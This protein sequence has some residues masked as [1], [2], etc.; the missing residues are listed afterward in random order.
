MVAV[1]TVTPHSVR[2]WVRLERS[3]RMRLLLNDGAKPVCSELFDVALSPESTGAFTYPEDFPSAG[4]LLANTRYTF[5]LQDEVGRLI[6]AG[7]FKTPAATA[8]DAPQSWSLAFVS[9]HQPFGDDGKLTQQ[10]N[11][12]LNAV[13]KAVA[14]FEPD[15]ILFLGDQIYSDAP[16]SMSLFVPHDDESS[17]IEQPADDVR[18]RYDQRYRQAWHTPAWQAL[19]SCAATACVPD[20]HDI[21]DNWGSDVHH[22]EPQWQKV[23]EAALDAAFS[24]QG[25]R[26]EQIAPGGSF[27]QGFRWQNAG[28]MLLDVRTQRR[29]SHE[30]RESQ[31]V[32]PIQM[33]RLELFL[34]RSADLPVVF[35]AISV[36][37]VHLPQWISDM[38]KMIPVAGTDLD[39]RWSNP[40]WVQTRDRLLKIL[41][42]H[43]HAHPHQQIVILSGDI[44]AGW[45]VSLG[46]GPEKVNEGGKPILQFV[47]SAITNGESSIVG[48]LSNALLRAC[49]A[50]SGEVAGLHLQDVPGSE[51]A[52]ANPFGGLN[53]GFVQVNRVQEKTTVRLQLVSHGQGIEAAEPVT[54]FDSGPL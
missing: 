46:E 20:D 42:D 18:R 39:D 54:V 23:R 30:A 8:E 36:P 41:N 13:R 52:L 4:M 38:G 35:L 51:G 31:I 16:K 10:A 45:A 32:D 53:A 37:V 44:H 6:G 19:H 50:M 25:Q 47:S 22:N 15:V 49:K 5:E 9:C 1:G 34:R 24:W 43:R 2:L 27:Q 26:S 17:V 3:K 14:T 12:M 48:A 28:I 33:D 7:R 29:V 11:N 40:V 21:I